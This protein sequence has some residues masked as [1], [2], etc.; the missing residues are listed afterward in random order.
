MPRKSA[1]TS[2]D[3][4]IGALAARQHGVVSRAQLFALGARAHQIDDRVHSGRLLSLHRGVYAVGHAALRVE[5]RWIAAVLACGTGA[6]LSHVDAAALWELRPAGAGRVHVT[7]P[8]RNGRRARPGIA[9]HRPSML[10]DDEKTSVREIAVTTPARTLLD[11]AEV[12]PRP[13]LVRAVEQAE[14]VR[15]LDLLDLERVI[16][17]HPGRA[18]ARRLLRVLAEQFGH[19]SVTRSELEVMFLDLC[20]A[21]GLPRPLVNST[22]AGLE[23]DFLWPR[24]GLV[25]EV[26]GYRFHGTRT[27]FERDRERDAVL[28]AAGLRVLR[29]TYRAITRDR[30]R[31]QRTL[32]EIAA[33]PPGAFPGI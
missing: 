3:D 6:V 1:Q 14:V 29:F 19:T 26:D 5:G 31:V 11:L 2:L 32:R 16:A 21:A 20:A 17:R 18:G 8:T 33:R 9:V 7:V 10:P 22:V 4:R 24:L 28:L 25:A 27:A 15:A 12:V 13:A 23:V 30:R